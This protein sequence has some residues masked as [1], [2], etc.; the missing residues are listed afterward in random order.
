MINTENNYLNNVVDRLSGKKNIN[1][2][3]NTEEN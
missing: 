1:K 3:I 2:T